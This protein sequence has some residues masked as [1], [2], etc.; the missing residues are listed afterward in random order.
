MSARV[1]DL[2]ADVAAI[3]RLRAAAVLPQ[4]AALCCVLFAVMF[5][6]IGIN[7]WKATALLLGVAAGLI[8]A[9]RAIEGG[10]VW[11]VGWL[12]LRYR[13]PAS[14][15][16]SLLRGAWSRT[17][18]AQRSREATTSFMVS[19]VIYIGGIVP[20]TLA[21]IAVGG[22]VW[23]W[24]IVYAPIAAVAARLWNRG[25]R[26]SALRLQELRRLDQRL[27]A[28]LLRSFDDDDMPLGK[29]YHFFWFLF[30]ARQTLTLES[31]VVDHVWRLG[32][33]IAIGKPG[34]QLSPLGAAREYIP[35]GRW[36][37]SVLGYLSDA[38]YVVSVLGATPGL[39]WEYEQMQTLGKT[40]DV[41]VVFP[42]H[43]ADEL[44][45]RWTVLQG[46][47]APARAIALQWEPFIGVPL[48]AFFGSDGVTIFYCKYRYETAYAAA[49]SRLFTVLAND[50]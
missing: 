26:Q 3:R 7:G 16:R 28:I 19:A 20:A 17:P 11:L 15:V 42:P 2:N 48:L 32:P 10:A 47:F 43:E 35:D 37:R 13:A 18:R 49:F 36:R 1:V 41:L 21:A 6:A 33:V 34:E 5:V 38:R 24:A 45:R 8:T 27:P 50:P 22:H 14:A 31:F 9:A 23:I 25:R 4:F 30:T 40:R 39:R 12:P 29:R 44:Q 46:I